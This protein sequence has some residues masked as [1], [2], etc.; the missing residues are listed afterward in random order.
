MAFI[1]VVNFTWQ[2]SFKQIEYMLNPEYQLLDFLGGTFWIFQAVLLEELTFRAVLLYLLIRYLGIVKACLLSS[3]AFG[4]YHW[5]SYDIIGER[6]VLLIYVFLVTG[7]GGW[8]FA[9]AYAK[10][11]SLYLP[12]GLHLGWNLITAIVFSAGPIGNQLFIPVGEVFTHS[13]WVTLI[14]FT[15]QAIVAPGVV[16]WFLHTRYR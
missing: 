10:T 14:F 13:D 12:V 2:A 15:L 3:I 5:F 6:P 8:M 4:I 16:T 1:A 9:F 11:Q 7:C